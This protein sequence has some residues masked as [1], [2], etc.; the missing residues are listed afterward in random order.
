ME[1]LKLDQTFNSNIS[2]ENQLL[3]IKLGVAIV[4]TLLIILLIT[5]IFGFSSIPAHSSTSNLQNCYPSIESSVNLG[6]INPFL[7]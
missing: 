5:I 1:K 4:G 2:L 3:I 6:S 7:L